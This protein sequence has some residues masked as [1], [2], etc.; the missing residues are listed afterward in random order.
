MAKIVQVNMKGIMTVQFNDIIAIPQNYSQF[1]DQFL[2]IRVQRGEEDTEDKNISAWNIIAFRNN[3][4]DIQINF[5]NPMGI[6]PT[7]VRILFKFNL[8]T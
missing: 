8:E 3:E 2:K 6:S 1:N 4:M 7:L 5:T